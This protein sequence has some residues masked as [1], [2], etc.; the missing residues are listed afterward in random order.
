[1]HKIYCE[2]GALTERLNALRDRRLIELVHFPYDPG[3]RLPNSS[4]G[5]P[6]AAMIA[7]LNMMLDELPGVIAD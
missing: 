3:S 5:V 6:S 4:N 7:D 1:M 2:H